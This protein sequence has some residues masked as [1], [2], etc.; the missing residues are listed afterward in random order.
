ML[1][2][3]LVSIG[4]LFEELSDSIG[5]RKVTSHEESPYTMAFLSLF[6]GTVCFVIISVVKNDLFIFKLES[7]PTFLVRVVFEIIQ[8]YVSV[9]AIAQ[10]D[11]TTFCFLRTLTIPLLLLADLFLGY[12][13]GLFGIVGISVITL[14]ILLLFSR[15]EIKKKG[16]GFVIFSAI[17]AVFTI[18][19]F[20]YNIT[21]FNS[22][23][24]EQL[25]M[26]LILLVTFF[27]IALVKVKENPFI[28]LTKP[29]FLLQSLSVGLGGMIESFAYNYGAASLIIAAKRSSAIF[30]SLLSGKQY[31]KEKNIVF[32]ILITILLVLGLVF[33]SLN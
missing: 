8:L 27:F 23:V 7:L 30:W 1:G 18:S 32:K 11:R 24:A 13:L 4:T 10:A 3:I 20:K 22:V 28:F 2:I 25:F 33:L 14:T 16:S 21:N 15:H 9:L 6:W 12:K 19:L 31:F 5:K 17:N 26:Y 29:I